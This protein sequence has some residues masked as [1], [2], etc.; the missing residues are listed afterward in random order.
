[1][2]EEIHK[3]ITSLTKNVP[4]IK[5]S[6]IFLYMGCLWLRLPVMISDFHTWIYNEDIPYFSAIYCIPFKIKKLL[7]D[8]EAS[9]LKP[10]HLPSC[11]WLYSRTAY[12]IHYYETN[13]KLSFPPINYP[14]I[15][16]RM[17]SLLALPAEAYLCLS[18]LIQ[19]IKLD[20]T[21]RS[22]RSSPVVD[23]VAI[24]IIVVKS[25]NRH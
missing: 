15:A 17:L 24:I 1:M 3:H 14:V 10:R 12:M 13:F 11:E 9:S 8:S 23:L 16:C 20:F 18:R 2:I 7:T 5:L 22:Y 19:L 21:Y 4:L 6:V 25:I